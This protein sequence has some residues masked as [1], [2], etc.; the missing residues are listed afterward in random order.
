MDDLKQRVGE[1]EKQLQETKQEVS[2]TV[3]N[4]SGFNQLH[5]LTPCLSTGGDGAGPAAGGA[6]GRAAAG[7]G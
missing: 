7:G 6:A 2:I 3:T 5:G 4:L 1:L